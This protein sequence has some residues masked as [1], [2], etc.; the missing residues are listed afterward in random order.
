[1]NP[2][3]KNIWVDQVQKRFLSEAK[4]VSTV[5]GKIEEMKAVEMKNTSVCFLLRQLFL[6]NYETN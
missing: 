3:H 2:F 1:M 4:H 5:T 6:Q